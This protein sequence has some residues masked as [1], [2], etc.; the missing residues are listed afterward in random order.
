[1]KEIYYQNQKE[2]V[3]DIFELSFLAPGL[4]FS[5]G[6]FL[7]LYIPQGIDPYRNHREFT[8]VSTPLELPIIKIAF[9][10]TKSDFKNFL[11]NLKPNQTLNYEGPYG[12]FSINQETWFIVQGIGVTPAVSMIKDEKNNSQKITLLYFDSRKDFP[13]QETLNN[14]KKLNQNLKILFLETEM[15]PETIRENVNNTGQQVYI[16]GSPKM[17]IK[18][19]QTLEDSGFVSENI[20]TDEFVGY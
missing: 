3:P 4:N 18:T 8:I 13:Y 7:D 15:K 10:H 19:K 11:L 14:Q 1:M 17:V 2:I 6:Q 16:A 9:R 12:N 20:F 5:S